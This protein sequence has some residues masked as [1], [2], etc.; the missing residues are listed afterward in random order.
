MKN[1]VEELLEKDIE[2]RKDD[3]YLYSCACKEYLIRNNIEIT[4]EIETMLNV[5][6]NSVILQLPNY[7]SVRRTRAKIQSENPSLVDEKTAKKRNRTRYMVAN[8]V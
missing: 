4:P 8:F 2:T 7:E 5:F 6:S 3:M 1:I